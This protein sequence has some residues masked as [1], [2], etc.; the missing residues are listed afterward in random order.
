ASKDIVSSFLASFYTKDRV[1]IG[2][3]VTVNGVTGIIVDLDK[4]SITID[5]SDSK[6]IIPLSTLIKENIEIYH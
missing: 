4:T 3:K 6:I 5:T 2:D 1:K